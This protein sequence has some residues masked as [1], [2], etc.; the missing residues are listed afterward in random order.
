MSLPSG[1]FLLG[2]LVELILHGREVRAACGRQLIQNLVKALLAEVGKG[3]DVTSLCLFYKV[4]PIRD[5]L[6]HE[7]GWTPNRILLGVDGDTTSDRNNKILSACN[8]Y[9]LR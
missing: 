7:F 6:R 4:F 9:N 3:A 8:A 1:R 2:G 5:A